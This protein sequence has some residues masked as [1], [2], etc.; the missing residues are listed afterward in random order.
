MLDPAYLEGLS[1]PVKAV[2]ARFLELYGPYIEA[3]L[4]EE[5]ERRRAAEEQVRRLTQ[6]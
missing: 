4:D 1:A 6:T 2:F 3:A 5:W